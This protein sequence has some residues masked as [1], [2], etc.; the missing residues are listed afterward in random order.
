MQSSEMYLMRQQDNQE[1]L[2]ARHVPY[3]LELFVQKLFAGALHDHLL[4]GKCPAQ[5]GVHE[6]VN[7]SPSTL[8]ELKSTAK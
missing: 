5:T 8:H 1:L 3:V 7:K 6:A 2:F 4:I